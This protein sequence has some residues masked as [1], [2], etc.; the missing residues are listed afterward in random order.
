MAEQQDAWR[1][2]KKGAERA[3][4]EVATQLEE[5]ERLYEQRLSFV[6]RT[7]EVVSGAIAI[8]DSL[9]NARRERIAAREKHFHEERVAMHDAL[10]PVLEG[11]YVHMTKQRGA[12][13]DALAAIAPG[14]SSSAMIVSADLESAAEEV[15]RLDSDLASLAARSKRVAWRAA[16]SFRVVAA[17]AAAAK[18]GAGTIDDERA[19]AEAA[20]DAAAAE[21]ERTRAAA[22]AA[23]A[24]SP[25]KSSGGRRPARK[26]PA[27]RGS[28]A[29]G[30][31]A[32]NARKGAAA[33]V[34]SAKPPSV[35][36]LSWIKTQ[37][38]VV[39]QYPELEEIGAKLRAL[40]T[41]CET[42]QTKAA[43]PGL[44]VT[45]DSRTVTLKAGSHKGAPIQTTPPFARSTLF[46]L[47]IS[48]PPNGFRVGVCR[49]DWDGIERSAAAIS[50]PTF[51]ATANGTLLKGNEDDGGDE[52]TAR[53][54]RWGAKL[55][56][57]KAVDVEVRV[58]VERSVVSFDVGGSTASLEGIPAECRLFVSFGDD[59]ENK[60][61]A[62]DVVNAKESK[63]SAKA[64][65]KA[66]PAKKNARGK[67]T[68][69]P[70]GRG[71][72]S[73]AAGG[74]SNGPK[75]A[76]IVEVLPF[77]TVVVMRSARSVAEANGAATA[78]ASRSKHQLHL[79][80]HELGAAVAAHFVA[81]A[82]A[83]ELATPLQLF[84]HFE[85]DND[86]QL[87]LREFVS[88]CRISGIAPQKLSN[89]DLQDLF[90]WI[91]RKHGGVGDSSA[92]L[93]GLISTDEFS[94]F[95]QSNVEGG[96]H[97]TVSLE[98][99]EQDTEPVDEMVAVHVPKPITTGGVLRGCVRG[100]DVSAVDV[101]SLF[102]QLPGWARI[103]LAYDSDAADGLYQARVG[104]AHAAKHGAVA[105]SHSAHAAVVS[106]A[107][108]HAQWEGVAVAKAA[109]RAALDAAERAEHG[110]EFIVTVQS[111]ITMARAAQGFARTTAN[112]ALQVADDVFRR[113]GRI[114][115]FLRAHTSPVLA[116]TVLADGRIASGGTHPDNTVRLWDHNARRNEW[117]TTTGLI[118]NAD[119][120]QTMC[121][122]C[123][124]SVA[125][126]GWDKMVHVW[127][128]NAV[129]F[130]VGDEVEANYRSKGKWYAAKVLAVQA[131]GA[132][133]VRYFDGD[134]ESNLAA[135]RLRSLEGG[136][137]PKPAH[138][139]LE[140][141]S[142]T[143]WG[144]VELTDGRLASC[145][146]DRTVK[147]W[148][149]AGASGTCV[150][151]LS[152]HAHWVTCVA[153]LDDGRI[154]T[155]SYD[156][157]IRVWTLPEVEPEYPVPGPAAGA[158]C[159]AV[160][161]GHQASV[162]TLCTLPGGV[163]VS[164]GYDKTVRVW[165]VGARSGKCARTLTGHTDWVN[166]IAALPGDDGLVA[167]SSEDK[168]LRVWSIRNGKCIAVLKGH[169]RGVV[170]VTV[171]KGGNLVSSSRDKLLCVWS[172]LHW[173]KGARAASRSPSRRAKKIA[174]A[175]A[176][177][178]GT[179]P[180]IAIPTA[181]APGPATAR[182]AK[183]GRNV[184]KKKTKKI[185]A[186]SAHP[187]N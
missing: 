67:G 184:K 174:A 28:E 167:T 182:K 47:H 165:K 133:A 11:L 178:L 130:S 156:E 135:E 4:D 110:S 131:D 54:T 125:T 140:G 120:V 87:S 157:T 168:T 102:E 84:H 115:D 166:G 44:A 187:R 160:L 73:A 118:G 159:V 107:N 32:T 144:V 62:G 56:G 93:D 5:C 86:R 72:K 45:N 22:K 19:A 138:F 8:A 85:T 36:Q 20:A 37:T 179:E 17:N 113:A 143:V 51:F 26:Q 81:T 78:S 9:A 152:G 153:Q 82:R 63:A 83:K 176:S 92:M 112:A 49:A 183:K 104:A 132:Y 117:T 158:T 15:K 58:D 151:T 121:A 88:G 40:A 13:A 61:G 149:L 2:G 23:A 185:K 173:E 30:G 164:G 169:S 150:A 141:H 66:T 70:K 59:D 80:K 29:A 103:R 116:L 111:S 128:T 10:F 108:A 163:I 46:R 161:K 94:A 171:L 50:G 96:F 1:E 18:G 35:L 106:A 186:T 74:G 99:E 162:R 177:A 181:S 21:A 172:H 27:K 69:P 38:D 52:R 89:D 76:T 95:I 97:G 154:A 98:K 170:G 136:V 148:Q 42:W 155:G 53:V 105:A 175:A 101:M 64:S 127:R 33:P 48:N 24:A 180:V 124:G 137:Q 12:A 129:A 3:A 77:E 114:D 146:A 147:I 7:K 43:G 139:A 34:R 142:E 60:K 55:K 41:I 14:A 91:D 100:G 145:S 119:S 65:A 79:G 57:K 122:L 39:L 75:A 68:S 134:R 90:R 31:R 71:G 126:G 109:H 6:H 16:P 123:D 25:S